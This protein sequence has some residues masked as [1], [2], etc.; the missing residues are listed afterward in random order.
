MIEFHILYGSSL[1]IKNGAVTPPTERYL[2]KD[3]DHLK[4][5]TWY[6]QRNKVAGYL[7][8]YLMGCVVPR[9]L[10]PSACYCGF[11]WL[12]GVISVKF[13]ILIPRE[14]ACPQSK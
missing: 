7:M 3:W 4:G 8:R 5:F 2:E 13:A 1:N 6:L 10:C 12:Q 14:N 9:D 11:A